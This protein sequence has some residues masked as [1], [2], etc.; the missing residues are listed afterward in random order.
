MRSVHYYVLDIT[1]NDEVG[2][3]VEFRIRLSDPKR[4]YVKS[5]A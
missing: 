3:R 2:L 4:M 5:S 1:F